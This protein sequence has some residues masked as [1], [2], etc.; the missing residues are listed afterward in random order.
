M[1]L[2]IDN[3]DSFVHTLTSYFL[4]LNATVWVVRNDHIDIP[5]IKSLI[6]GGEL[7][8]V[9]ISPGPKGPEECG[10]CGRVL[11]AIEG[12]VPVLG[13]CLGHQVVAHTYGAT[14][15]RGVRPMHG[16]VSNVHTD[17]SRLF[18][19]IP[20]SFRVT[21]YHSLV[22][23]ENSLPEYFSVNAHSD[24][25]A[26]MAISHTKHPLYGVQFHPEAVLSDYGHKLLSNFIMLCDERQAQAAG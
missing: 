9:I 25:G 7:E 2:M 10:E 22:V 12:L 16:K 26:I 6:A 4:E 21:R 1:Y 23:D 19:G 14:V 17:G 18:T 15:V 3:Y 24:D 8:G 5:R 13:V 11:H 20:R